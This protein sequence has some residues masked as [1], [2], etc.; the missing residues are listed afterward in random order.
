MTDASPAPHE[1]E[2]INP[3]HG[4]PEAEPFF[5]SEGTFSAVVPLS[6]IGPSPVTL[7]E[8][9]GEPA[10]AAWAVVA[11]RAGAKEEEETLVPRRGRGASYAPAGDGP[12]QSWAVTA[13]AIALSVVAGVA[14]GGYLV[15][16]SQLVAE[17][18][19]E[20]RAAEPAAPQVAAEVP[21]PAEPAP[22]PEAQPSPDPAPDVA[23]AKATEAKATEAKAA[24]A[25]AE[26]PREVARA[27]KVN[28]PAADLAATAHAAE[29]P[30]RRA[31]EPEPRAERA[32]RAEAREAAPAPRP[33]AARAAATRTREAAAE[34]RATA[35]P[36]RQRTLPVSSP[37]PS[38][39]AN[40]VIRW[41]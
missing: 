2:P 7:R 20:H 38:A 24:E 25:K 23:E 22:A 34:R 11:H 1:H 28:P 32:P 13:V 14:A 15:W 35:P 36:E 16:T 10:E 26:E 27:P 4:R 40:K 18:R 33:A 17:K 39:K 21:A 8:G 19:L 41:P 31:A 9:S 37:P 29:A 12:R 3:T 6:E 30:R 5:P